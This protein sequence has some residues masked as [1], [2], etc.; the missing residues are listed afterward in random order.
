M[1]RTEPRPTDYEHDFYAWLQN[2]AALLKAGRLA[3][4]DMD[5]LIE[6][7]EALGRSERV[8]LVSRLLVLLTHLL[9]WQF[10][11]SARSSSWRGTIDEQR[12]QIELRLDD[13]PSLRRL[14]PESLAYAY[15]K[16]VRKA[17]FETGLATEAFP[18]DCP[19]TVDEVLD[20]DFWP[21]GFDDAGQG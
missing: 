18:T 3:E 16:A 20:P 6:E 10:Q 12:T 8:E 7:I 21:G 11:P 2:Q 15:P 19:Y 1:N 4:V 5:N 14:I 9:K 17:A 13:S